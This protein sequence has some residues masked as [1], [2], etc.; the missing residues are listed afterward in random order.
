MNLEMSPVDFLDKITSLHQRSAQNLDKFFH[1]ITRSLTSLSGIKAAT[2]YTLGSYGDETQEHKFLSLRSQSG[3]SYEY[4]SNFQIPLQ[5]LAGR[6]VIEGSS[7][8]VENVRNNSEFIDQ[9][10]IDK[11]DLKSAAFIPIIAGN[12]I[13]PN[14]CICIYF[15]T[16]EWM[17]GYSS[18]SDRF[19]K[20]IKISIDRSI[21]YT[22]LK[23]RE[24][25]VETCLSGTDL[26]SFFHKSLRVI[27]SYWNIEAASAFVVDRRSEC[28]RLA[29]TTG[30]ASELPKEQIFYRFS[31][32][33]KHTVK[34]F[35]TG[36]KII[37]DRASEEKHASKF[38]EILMHPFTSA[39]LLPIHDVSH[40]NGDKKRVIGV[41]RFINKLI[42]HLDIVEPAAFTWDDIELAEFAADIFSTITNLYRRVHRKTE[43]FER[44]FHSVNSSA[45]GLR[46]NLRLLEENDSVSSALP[47][48]L[49][50]AIR[51]SLAQITSI[52]DQISRFKDR[53]HLLSI[54]PIMT[55]IHIGGELIAKIPAMAD[56]ISQA[57]ATKTP[58]IDI[59]S[60]TGDN[61]Y[62]LPKVI[63]DPDLIMT[64]LRNLTENS[65][66]YSYLN[67]Q[68]CLTLTYEVD[69]EFLHIFFTDN[70]IGVEAE[71]QPF[72]FNEG[73]QAENAIRRDP[74]GTGLG[75][76]QS[77]V[78]MKKI[79][80]DLH[81]INN[82]K[83][84]IGSQFEIKLQRAK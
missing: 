35:K 29:S 22:K 9:L 27:K 31:Q 19:M 54:K 70:G 60:F 45:V 56:S 72:I 16:K 49:S 43:E 61:I 69:H 79:G 75:L 10:L 30:I 44:V 21:D 50:Y 33:D 1:E 55:T 71:D 8:F 73:Y 32:N 34:V 47:L 66:K 12:A 20:N 42:P 76:Y 5:T 2:V 48:H 74:T 11:F 41:C 51:D 65:T 26:S 58:N 46:E 68:L 64:V 18:F 39:I 7:V 77:K 53:D 3:L 36:K 52:S 25:I 4:Y 15:D 6:A 28:L 24:T 14:M 83:G 40:F 23:L 78:L 37:L 59:S 38:P 13:I 62:K 84:T 81:F 67:R 80:G 57:Y 63:G 17:L 82:K